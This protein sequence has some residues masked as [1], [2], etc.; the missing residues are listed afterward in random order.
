MTTGKYDEV[1][2]PFLRLMER[3]LH[4]NSHK[5]DRPSWV[6]LSRDG[7]MFEVYD[8]AAKLAAALRV[9]DHARIIEH[10]ADV[11]NS[12]MMLLDAWGL[13]APGFHKRWNI[14]P[15]CTCPACMGELLK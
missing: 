12:A 10:A 14:R 6:N 7:A 4:S 2:I 3:E 15:G 11:A 5:G 13:L 1:L 8:H 9:D